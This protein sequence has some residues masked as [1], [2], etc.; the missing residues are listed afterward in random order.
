[1]MDLLS[2]VQITGALIVERLRVLKIDI[3]IRKFGHPDAPIEPAH[4]LS[5][6]A[7]QPLEIAIPLQSLLSAVYLPGVHPV[8]RIM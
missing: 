8:G 1:M 6:V 7:R 4:I 3:G 2:T 5:N